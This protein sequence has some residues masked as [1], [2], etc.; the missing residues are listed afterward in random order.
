M[1]MVVVYYGRELSIESCLAG[2]HGLQVMG[3]QG[4][5]YTGMEEYPCACSGSRGCKGF[6][7]GGALGLVTLGARP[8]DGAGCS[9]TGVGWEKQS[10]TGVKRIGSLA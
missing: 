2:T 5:K 10:V 4:A 8:L 6:N 9:K 3:V 7:K 1:V